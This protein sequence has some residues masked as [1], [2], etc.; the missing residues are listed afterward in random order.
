M[1]PFSYYQSTNNTTGGRP[2]AFVGW[3]VEIGGN[4]GWGTIQKFWLF[5]QYWMGNWSVQSSTETLKQAFDDALAGSSWVDNGHY[6]HMQIYGY[7]DMKFLDFDHAGD[8]PH[9]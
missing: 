4:K 1:E 7:Q 2:S 3:D 5:R 9:Q 6:S 8:W